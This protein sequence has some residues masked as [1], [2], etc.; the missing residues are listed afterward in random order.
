MPADNADKK[1]PLKDICYKIRGILFKIQ[2]DLGTKFQEKH[3]SR[4]L[5]SILSEQN[6]KYKTEVP[7]TII[8]NGLLLG[9]F[10]AD[11]VI[12]NVILLEL[13]TVDY[14]T[15]NHFKQTL[16][17]LQALNLPVGY[18]VNFR[19]RP[20]QIKR[21]INTKSAQSAGRKTSALSAGRSKRPSAFI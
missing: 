19:I 11:M 17:Y 12:E 21:I 3:Y 7:F 4:A 16:R 9:K 13:K 14:L 2:N 5:C 20:L 18:V 1:F 15:T 10:R 6:I 8:Y